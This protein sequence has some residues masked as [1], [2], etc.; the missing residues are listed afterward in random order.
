MDC[1]LVMIVHVCLS[2]NRLR[3]SETMDEFKWH[4]GF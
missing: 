1:H 3:S 2:N 4:C